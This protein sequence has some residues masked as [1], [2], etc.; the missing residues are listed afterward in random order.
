[1]FRLPESV[2]WLARIVAIT[3]LVIVLGLLALQH[4]LIYFPRPYSAAQLSHLPTGAIEI[5][6]RTPSGDQC[7]FYVPSAQFPPRRVWAMFAGNGSVALDWLD[8]VARAD[9]R[10]GFLLVDYPGYGKSAGLASPQT[11]AESSEAAAARLASQLHLE[12]ENLRW[13]VI[14]HS[15]GCAAALQFAATH[16]VDR[17]I[18]LAPFTTMREMA[19]RVVGW[20]LC[21]TLRHNFDNRARLAELARR[22][23][24]PAVTIFHGTDDTIIPEAM[25]R[26]LAALH[27]GVITF[28]SVEDADHNSIVDDA[29][30]EILKVIAE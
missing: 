24:P 6:S 1:M 26:G 8:V 20:P 27:P 16:P 18:L 17:V 19:R 4:R 25:G 30:T 28:R 10:D 21:Y 23:V 3:I 29:E 2:R 14:G 15:I 22:K 12:P 9:R 13:G 11:I 5:V 7:A